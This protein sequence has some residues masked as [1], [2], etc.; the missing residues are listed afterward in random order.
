MLDGD[1]FDKLSIVGKLLRKK[2]EPFGGIQ[3]VLTGDFFQVSARRLTAH[4]FGPGRL[5]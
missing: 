5:S 3:V 1:L 4:L 2:P